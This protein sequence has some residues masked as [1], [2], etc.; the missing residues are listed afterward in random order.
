M[1]PTTFA[2]PTGPVRAPRTERV[3]LVFVLLALVTL[4]AVPILVNRRANA[5]REQIEA[6]EPAR[7]EVTSLEFNLVREMAALSELMLTA[8]P[9]AREEYEEALERED[10]IYRELENH[11]RA[12]SPEVVERLAEVRLAALLWHSRV[13]DAED[14]L[15][16]YGE[17]DHPRPRRERR[18]FGELLILTRQLDEAIVE[19]TRTVRA[20]IERAERLGMSVT[21]ALGVLAVLTGAAAALLAGR[22][23]QFAIESERRRREAEV[24]LE[25][26]ARG[27]ELRERLLRGITHDV[28]NPLGAAKGY[29]EL[30]AL[31]VRAPIQP[32]Q[33]PL[34]TGIQRSVDGALRIINDLLDLA[35]V[36]SGRLPIE[37]KQVDLHW[38]LK[39]VLE[40]QRAQIEAAGHRLTLD[41]RP[42][43][44]IIRTDP[45]RVQQIVQNL[46]SNG[47]K[48][49]PPPGAITVRVERRE[50]TGSGR[51]AWAAVCVQDTGPGIPPEMRD[52]IFEEFTRV[53]DDGRVEGHGLGLAI[54]RRIARLL[55]GDLRLDSSSNPGACFVLL[56]PLKALESDRSDAPGV[57]RPAISRP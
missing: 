15:E 22:A 29:A 55:G 40:V 51:G 50:D 36:E 52:R 48:Y 19:H 5:L 4:V 57:S 54:A 30:L 6:A 26:L 32:E 38:V 45:T 42:G 47:A 16:E 12:L 2:P 9:S 1:N 39:E 7:N 18:L 43:E 17:P 34:V 28:K 10:S 8:D 53:K 31:G 37:P 46:L 25:E 41:S 44:F 11:A 13:T 27:A 56:L 49:T 20:R 33:V 23:R 3:V 24:A 35:R 14:L 21:V